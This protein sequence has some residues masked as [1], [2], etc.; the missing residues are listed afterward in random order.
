MALTTAYLV[1][2]KNLSA[3]F[4]AIISAKAPERF[5]NRF[6]EQLE[7]TSSNDRLYIA[8]LKGLGFLDDSGVPTQRY[9]NFLDQTRSG[10]ILAQAVEEAYADLFAL[11]KRAYEMS[12]ED[13][14]NK[15]RT[16]T[17]GQKSDH[18][19]TLMSNTF[20][21]LCDYAEWNVKEAT[22]A[23][24]SQPEK[25][26]HPDQEPRRAN[27]ETPMIDS[28]LAS[29]HYNIQI[30]LPESRDIA[31]YDAI[32]RSLKEHLLGQ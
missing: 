29:L 25:V 6:L 11:N 26:R 31:V 27:A 3:F 8:L 2:T 16:L 23:T 20:K 12:A 14:K 5:T 9:F 10:A 24:V 4:N 19:L 28:H 21:A 30:H 13:V 7:F 18:V 17:Q 22:E 32:F 1:T 15:L